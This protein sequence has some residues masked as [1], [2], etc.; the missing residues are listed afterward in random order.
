MFF[1]IET[2]KEAP[3]RENKVLLFII[4]VSE[5]NM[6]VFGKLAFSESPEIPEELIGFN[7][8]RFVC[9]NQIEVF[10][11]WINSIEKDQW[12]SMENH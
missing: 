2:G 7:S 4:W 6:K 5:G 3:F 11:L 10:D 1:P 8:C 9:F 12:N